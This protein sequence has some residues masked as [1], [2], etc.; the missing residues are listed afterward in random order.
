MT[1]QTKK[2]RT[3]TSNIYGQTQ[4]KVKE[5][6]Q[7]ALQEKETLMQKSKQTKRR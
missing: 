6:L 4:H 1:I 3:H 7:A 2:K 5:K